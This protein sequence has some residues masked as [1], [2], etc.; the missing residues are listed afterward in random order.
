MM[1]NYKYYIIKFLELITV[2]FYYWYMHSRG[3]SLVCV[4]LVIVCCR[5]F[6]R[7]L[8]V[9]ASFIVAILLIAYIISLM[10]F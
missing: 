5:G 8:Y 3:L 4:V 6:F 9:L 1:K 7:I 2:G 10:I